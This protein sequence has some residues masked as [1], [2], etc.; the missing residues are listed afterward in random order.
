M[1]T[2]LEMYSLPK[3]NQVKSENLDRQ[4]IP[5]EVEAVVKKL[6]TNKIPGPDGFTRKFYQTLERN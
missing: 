1:D 4:I 5:S 6:P 3:V 2:F